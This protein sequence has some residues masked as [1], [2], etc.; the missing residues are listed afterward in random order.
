M[1][2][3]FRSTLLVI[4]G[5]AVIGAGAWLLDLG[6]RPEPREPATAETTWDTESV[7]AP[8]TMEPAQVVTPDSVDEMQAHET[9]DIHPAPVE[10]TAVAPVEP[11]AAVDDSSLPPLSPQT[12]AAVNEMINRSHE[13]LVVEPAAGGGEKVD[14]QGRFRSVPVAS[15][16][17]DGTVVVREVMQES[18]PQRQT[19]TPGDTE[20]TD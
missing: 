6:G 17:P 18:E 1:K 11:D 20:S 5:A 9:V 3:S 14:L 10:E 16:N 2:I 15:R 13:G 7:P 12:R 19:E 4:G 8:P